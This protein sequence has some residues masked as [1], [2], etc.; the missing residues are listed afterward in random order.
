[1]VLRPK[2][3]VKVFFSTHTANTMEQW[4]GMRK[5]WKKFEK[6]L[7]KT[8]LMHSKRFQKIYVHFGLQKHSIKDKDRF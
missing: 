5:D 7:P 4:I 3:K 1:M 6:I 2:Y 8:A